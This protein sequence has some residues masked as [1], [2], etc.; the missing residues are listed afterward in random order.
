MHGNKGMLIAVVFLALVL[1]WLWMNKDG[2]GCGPKQL[3]ER[4]RERENFTS[5]QVALNAKTYTFI[6]D[7]PLD[8]AGGRPDFSTMCGGSG[9]NLPAELRGMSEEDIQ[10]EIDLHY[11]KP[12]QMVDTADLLP[13]VDVS[14]INH[15]TDPA[16]DF[17]NKTVWHRTTSAILKPRSLECGA[18]MIRGDN[19]IFPDPPSNWF[20]HSRNISDLTPS[21][22]NKQYEGTI[23]VEDLSYNMHAIH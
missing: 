1:A 22:I 13:E 6:P 9:S 21:F 15:L 11:R 16:E 5:D 17:A 10:K 12:M 4:P 20:H 23:D 18:A 19:L 8:G 14:G 7:A 3:Q 2:C